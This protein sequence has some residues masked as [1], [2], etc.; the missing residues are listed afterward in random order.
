MTGQGDRN[1]QTDAGDVDARREPSD[2]GVA[3]DRADW[4]V[5]RD[6]EDTESVAVGDRVAFAKT[7]SAEDVEAFARVT[8]DTNRLHL[9]EDYAAG[10]RFGGPIVH[11][12]LLVGVVGAALARLPGVVVYLSQE[13]SFDRPV[14]I[15]DRVRVTCTVREQLGDGRYRVRTTI[16]GSYGNDFVTGQARILV[17]DPPVDQTGSNR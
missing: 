13:A 16:G 11:G 9:D 4:A 17:D 2:H 6:V 1:E 12:G 10:T 8:G 3:Y 5:E 14:G 7:I 15:G